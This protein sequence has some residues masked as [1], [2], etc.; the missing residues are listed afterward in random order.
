MKKIIITTIL[1]FLTLTIIYLQWG[2]DMEICNTRPETSKNA[3]F[4]DVTLIANKLYIFDKY[5]FAESV[6]VCRQFLE[7][8]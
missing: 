7:R 3:Y 4:E 6:K 1:S 8:S 5:D 2:R